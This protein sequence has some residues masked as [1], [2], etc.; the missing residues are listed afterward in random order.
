MALQGDEVDYHLQVVGSSVCA[1]QKES[2]ELSQ[3]RNLHSLFI[4]NFHLP[5]RPNICFFNKTSSLDLWLW[6]P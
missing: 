5:E 3:N 2:A 4:W 6:E 1:A